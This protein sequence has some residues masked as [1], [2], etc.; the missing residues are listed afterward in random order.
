MQ[1]KK[2]TNPFKD[3]CRDC[4]SFLDNPPRC[5]V[6]E[7]VFDSEE[8]MEN[9]GATCWAFRGNGEKAK[10]PYWWALEQLMKS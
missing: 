9:T 8:A 2:E 7:Y 4:V 6:K 1:P 10:D 3:T 5:T